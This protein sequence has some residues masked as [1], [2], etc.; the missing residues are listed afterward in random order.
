MLDGAKEA[1][2][3]RGAEA[4]DKLVALSG[5]RA[6]ERS[7]FI[8]DDADEKIEQK[9]VYT[10]HLVLNINFKTLDDHAKFAS[11]RHCVPVRANYHAG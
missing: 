3:E 10:Y 5:I 4:R 6:N 7:Q 1:R 8:D 2:G 9:V 11:H